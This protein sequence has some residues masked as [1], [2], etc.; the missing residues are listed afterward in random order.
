MG[1]WEGEAGKA[2]QGSDSHQDPCTIS[3]NEVPTRNCYQGLISTGGVLGCCI[4]NSCL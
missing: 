2:Q 3:V 1:Q 4:G